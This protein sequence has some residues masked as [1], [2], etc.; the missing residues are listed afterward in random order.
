M[1]IV[2]SSHIPVRIGSG[3]PPPFDEPCRERRREALSD[4][5]GLTQFGV[6]RITL[7]PGAWSSQ[8]HWHSHEDEL[9]YILSG[10]PTLIDDSGETQLHPGDVT[11]H[12]AGVPNGHHMINRTN[13]PVIYLVVGSRRPEIDSGSY[14]DVDLQIPANGTAQREYER[15]DGSKY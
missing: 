10:Q 13:I 14:P 1:P 7:P 15:K 12:K 11:T 9:V 6:H 2:K 3:Y 5:G 8:R 4:A